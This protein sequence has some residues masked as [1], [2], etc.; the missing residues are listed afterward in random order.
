MGDNPDA[1]STRMIMQSLA[2]DADKGEEGKTTL[3]T[4]F[5]TRLNKLN[6]GHDHRMVELFEANLR[7]G[8]RLIA[9]F[10]VCKELRVSLTD[11]LINSIAA[12]IADVGGF[13]HLLKLTKE[14]G[15]APDSLSLK[16][17]F[18]A[19]KHESTIAQS[20]RKLSEASALD[21]ATFEF[22]L[23]YPEQSFKISQLII[24]LQKNAYSA[25]T[26]VEKLSS[27]SLSA[28]QMST[29]ID[30]LN[31]TLEH[32]LYYPGVVDIL[33][34]QKQ[35]IDKIYEGTK[36]LTAAHLVLGDYFELLEHSPQQ[37]N[38]FAK[39]VLLLHNASLIN[40]H[41]LE[42]MRVVSTL[43][44]GA[45]H[46]MKHLQQADMLD[47][48][49]YQKICRHNGLLNQQKVIEALSNLPLMVTFRTE[50][51]ERMLDLM[52]KPTL[53]DHDMQEFNEILNGYF[54]SSEYSPGH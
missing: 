6:L 49:N 34:R 14:V 41:N 51:L 54:I 42:D 22:M 31:L 27:S 5:L 3:I 18:N 23:K 28:S 7:Y 39:N 43:G 26:L 47:T 48:K 9:L 1:I 25:T 45:F 15:I 40:Y 16:I 32:D 20:T 17:L 30:L 12:N 44:S 36:K 2:P 33:L 4:D 21:L 37:A 10:K 35:Y 53:S 11:E 13:A 46:F 50:E 19:A 52:N 29:A 24:N 38:I 8:N